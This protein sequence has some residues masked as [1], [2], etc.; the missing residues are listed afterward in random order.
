MEKFERGDVVEYHRNDDAFP[1][2]QGALG[3]VEEVTQA[4]YIQRARISWISK[5]VPSLWFDYA[6]ESFAVLRRV[7]AINDIRQG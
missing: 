2:Y 6:P 1:E 7:G 5:Y 3:V 4:G